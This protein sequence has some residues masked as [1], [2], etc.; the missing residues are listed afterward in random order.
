MRRLRAL[1]LT[2]E[3]ARRLRNGSGSGRVHSVF[4]R[5][6]NLLFDGAG[7]GRWV[8]LHGPGPIPAPFGIAC[9]PW[10]ATGGLRSAVVRV[11]EDTVVLDGCLRICL[12]GALVCDTL[13]PA[14]APAPALSG[15]LGEALARG[16]AGLFPAAAALLG[17][18]VP[19]ADPLAR[20]A[21]PALARLYAT[22]GARDAAGCL[23][24]ARALLGLD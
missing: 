23:T 4:P 9:E 13:L 8:S 1:R 22:T 21:T 17:R 19:P 16:A 6:V 5:T 20:A 7:S 18:A 15:C 3:A 12:G 24:A 14:R 2:A 10:P 11:E